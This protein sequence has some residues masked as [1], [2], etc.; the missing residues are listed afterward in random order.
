[1]KVGIDIGT[2]MTKAVLFGQAGEVLARKALHTT[3]LRPGPGR[4]EHDVEQLT[5][6]VL[7]LLRELPASDIDLIALTG[8]G[9]G[10]WLLDELARG[11]RTALSWLD[12]RGTGVC[13][14]WAA[15]GT[16]EAVFAHTRNAPFSGAGA[17][18]LAALEETDQEALDRAA[19]ATQCQHVVFERLT[20][21]RTATRS[22]AMVPVFDPVAGMY[23]DE[24]LRLTGTAPR[25]GL[26]P[27]I[28]DAP[29]L[30]APVLGEIADALGLGRHVRVATGPYDLPAAALGV[31]SLGP[32]DGVLVLGTTLACQVRVHGLGPAGLPVGLTLC[33]GDDRGWLRAMPAMVGT[34]CIDWILE[35]TRASHAELG[36]LLAASAPGA[37]GVA[38]LPFLSPAGERAPFAD[39]AARA[40]ITGLTLDTTA[41]D[42]VTAV[43]EALGYAARHCFEAAGLTGD[44]VVCGG[45]SSSP[46]LVQLIAD[47]LE[48]PLAVAGDEEPAARGAVMA[49][50]LAM[51]RDA[52]RAPLRPI[53]RPRERQSTDRYAHYLSRLASAR[54]D[55]WRGNVPTL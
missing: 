23:D 30:V 19:T 25:R 33:T 26:L 39:T 7:H 48:R 4:Y 10:L 11:V 28:A 35:L 42:V 53:V 52:S 32:G 8:Q 45:G 12:A 21:V 15:N 6:S 14:S 50:E 55:G 29:S 24:A 51:G 44:V 5:N 36:R 20:G 17:A 3:L 27:E 2:T 37:N 22:C 16:S 9:D 40:E 46:E 47:V 38:A 13:E 18:L 41:A 1:M 54:R 31:G 34:A 43:C 49:A